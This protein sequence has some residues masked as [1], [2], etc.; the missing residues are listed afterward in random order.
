MSGKLGGRGLWGVTL[1]LLLNLFLFQPQTIQTCPAEVRDQN[2]GSQ[3]AVPLSSKDQ[4][5]V[6]PL[7][8]DANSK[9]FTN[10]EPESEQ[11]IR[12]I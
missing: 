4:H 3:I 11:A 2:R 5:S 10:S 8:N 9:T 12:L 1:F 7:S 6:G